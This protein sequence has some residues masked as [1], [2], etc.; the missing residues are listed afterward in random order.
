MIR[1]GSFSTRWASRDHIQIERP[2]TGAPY[3]T[4]IFMKLLYI[5]ILSKQ[6]PIKTTVETHCS[7]YVQD[8]LLPN[9]MYQKY[10]IFIY[11]LFSH[12]A[13]FKLACLVYCRE[14]GL[15]S[16]F[17]KL[18]VTPMKRTRMTRHSIVESVFVL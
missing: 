15:L 16:L 2:Q 7:S 8:F 5:L 10:R 6:C 9:N 18:F 17:G 4:D 14:R 12:T 11:L 3:F 1:Y 13:F